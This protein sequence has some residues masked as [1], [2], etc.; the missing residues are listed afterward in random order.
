MTISKIS[1][2]AHGG[3]Y[4]LKIDLAENVTDIE[5]KPGTV[6]NLPIKEKSGSWS[7]DPQRADAGLFYDVQIQAFISGINQTNHDELMVLN[8]RKIIAWA[9]DYHGIEIVMG[10]L[11][12]PCRLM[13]SASNPT[14]H[15]NPSGFTISIKGKQTQPITVL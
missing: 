3:I 13:V 12:Q 2:S 5:T 15:L 11:D 6:I 14:D 1:G 8:D 7:Q 10:T 4:E 9:L